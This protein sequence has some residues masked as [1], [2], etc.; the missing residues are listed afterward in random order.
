VAHPVVAALRAELGP[1]VTDDPARLRTYEVDW[2]GRVAGRAVAA[3]APLSVHEVAAS[4]VICT[5]A[6]MGVVPQGGNTGL[7]AGAVPQDTVVLDLRRLDAVAADAREEIV[8]AGAGTTIE[9]LH[10]EAGALGLR[11]AVDLASRGT[12]T[13]GGTVATNAGGL[14]ARALGD[15]RA[16]LLG[17]EAVLADG[18]IVRHLPG[19]RRDNT[20]Y[21]WPALLC[22]SEGTLAVITQAQLRLCPLPTSHDVRLFAFASV[23][24]AVDAAATA[25]DLRGVE[26]VELVLAAGLNLVCSVT[27][28]RRPFAGDHAAVLLIERTDESLDGVDLPRSID[29]AVAQDATD[30]RSLWALRERHTEAIATRGPAHKLDVTLPRSRLAEFV[31]EVPTLVRG[32]DR[33]AEVWIFGHAGDGS[34]HV[35]VTGIAPEDESVAH[36]VLGAVADR[37]GSISTE[38][39]IGRAKARWLPMA[40]DAAELGLFG[41]LKSALDPTSI[42]NPGVLC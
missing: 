21:A 5:Q 3:V 4:L 19:V 33:S 10:R 18:T 24:D 39:G 11:Y 17:V 31:A 35:N 15:T 41:R 36:A 29:V 25:G 42:L 14:R 23:V 37:G 6:G 26:A 28:L 1:R 30:R 13:V 16:Q 20:G 38:H 2:T 8:T 12:A 40:R 7:V 27:G 22:G 32:I 34:V 9:V